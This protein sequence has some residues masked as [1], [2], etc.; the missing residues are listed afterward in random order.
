LN[1][2]T[3]ALAVSTLE[4]DGP[5][6]VHK[7]TQYSLPA[8]KEHVATT[9]LMPVGVVVGIWPLWNINVVG[10]PLESASK[11]RTAALEPVA[12]T[13]PN[14]MA[15]FVVVYEYVGMYGAMI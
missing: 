1:P 14:L 2:K 13:V 5:W 11:I 12:A 7:P 15:M 8:V 4:I 10:R 3:Y 9:V 6:E